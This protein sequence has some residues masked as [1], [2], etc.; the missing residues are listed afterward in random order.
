MGYDND[1]SPGKQAFGREYVSQMNFLGA[2][3][4]TPLSTGQPVGFV[5]DGDELSAG[6]ALAA[7]AAAS[8]LCG[9]SPVVV[10]A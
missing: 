5:A 4:A 3:F 6:G 10:T 9:A 1:F 7:G 8:G 2:V